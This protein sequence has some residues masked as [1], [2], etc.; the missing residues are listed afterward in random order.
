MK[1]GNKAQEKKQFVRKR[2]EKKLFSEEEKKKII[3]GCQR[4]KRLVNK[5]KQGPVR[6]AISSFLAKKKKNEGET[7]FVESCTIG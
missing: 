5:G 6:N 2:E 1:S 7:K 3:V 4:G